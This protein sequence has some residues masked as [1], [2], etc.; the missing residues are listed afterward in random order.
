MLE[1]RGII[2]GYEGSKPRRVLIDESQLHQYAAPIKSVKAAAAWLDRVGIAA[3]LPGRRARA[4]VALG[5]GLRLARGRVGG[6]S[7]RRAATS[8]RPRWRSAG[9]GRTSCPS[10]GLAC[11][12]KH[13]GALE[14]A[15]RAA[16]A[17]AALRADR[18]QRDS[19]GLPRR[20]A[21]VAAARGR[22]GG[23]RG[24]PCTGPELR[25][26]VGAE[27]KQVDAALVVLQRA[28]VLDERLR[29]RAAAGLGCDRRRCARPALRR[30]DAAAGGRGA[31]PARGRRCSRRQVSCPPLISAERSA[32]A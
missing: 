8:S 13:F 32:G 15:R 20:R 17:A 14:R 24:R 6:R 3:L 16:P 7:T 1:R 22:R 5:S 26:L 25:A 27:K 11:V 29:R 18:P 9:R 2:S 19:G 4:A 10:R 23:A 28:L 31:S 21:H 12:G 30:L